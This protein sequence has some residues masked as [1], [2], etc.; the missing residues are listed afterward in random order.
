[1]QMF[2]QRFI[3]RRAGYTLRDRIATDLQSSFD[4]DD[5]KPDIEKVGIPEAD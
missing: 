3:P 5:S 1:M 2:G 4:L